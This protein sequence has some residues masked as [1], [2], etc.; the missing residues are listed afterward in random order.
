MDAGTEGLEA[1]FAQMLIGA[2][3]CLQRDLP[4]SAL[5]LIY[6][7]LDSFAWAANP[8]ESNICARFEAWVVKYLQPA[9]GS[10]LGLLPRNDF[11]PWDDCEHISNT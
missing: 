3:L 6:T 11:L 1:N 2:R 8:D 4:M 5:A 10:P 9:L 7:I